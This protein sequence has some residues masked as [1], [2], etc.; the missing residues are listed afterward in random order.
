M[1]FPSFIPTRHGFGGGGAR[2]NDASSTNMGPDGNTAGRSRR[3]AACCF[4]IQQCNRIARLSGV[5]DEDAAGYSISSISDGSIRYDQDDDHRPQARWPPV[6]ASYPC[7]RR[8]FRPALE[9]NAGCFA[10]KEKG[11]RVGTRIPLPVQNP[12]SVPLRR[13]PV[14]DYACRSRGCPRSS[15]HSRRVPMTEAQNPS[16][17]EEN[18]SD[19]DSAAPGTERTARF[20]DI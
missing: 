10:K 8:G 12:L 2:T 11:V 13:P 1:A 7:R 18:W 19:R 4:S 17:R 6:C 5:S 20:S 9:V 15:L 16:R 14:P 3:T